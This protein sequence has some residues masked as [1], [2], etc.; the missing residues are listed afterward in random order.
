[1]TDLNAAL[2]AAILHDLLLIDA[3]GDI[4]IR[5]KSGVYRILLRS[6]TRLQDEIA[7]AFLAAVQAVLD[8]GVTVEWAPRYHDGSQMFAASFTEAGARRYVD[9]SNGGLKLFRRRCLPWQEV[10]ADA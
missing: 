4:A 2:R 3:N 5:L 1:M 7:D 9:E 8:E 6:N 10:P